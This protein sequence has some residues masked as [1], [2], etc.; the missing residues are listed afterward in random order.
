MSFVAISSV[1]MH[2]F[3]LVAHVQHPGYS[4]ETDSCRAPKRTCMK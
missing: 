2:N 1:Q 4:A 3:P